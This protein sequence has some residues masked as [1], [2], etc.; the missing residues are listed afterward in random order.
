MSVPFVLAGFPH[1]IDYSFPHYISFPSILTFLSVL[2]RTL[3]F[4]VFYRHAVLNYTDCF[5]FHWLQ[6][7]VRGLREEGAAIPGRAEQGGSGLGLCPAEGWWTSSLTPTQSLILPNEEEKSQTNGS[8]FI[9]LISLTLL[10]LV[11][12]CECVDTAATEKDNT[13][14][15]RKETIKF[16][17]IKISWHSLRHYAYDVGFHPSRIFTSKSNG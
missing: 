14:K 5:H 6:S 13:R 11:S 3:L 12:V 16:H 1:I 9:L 2:R 4:N 15:R 10:T 7:Y 17:I 8:L